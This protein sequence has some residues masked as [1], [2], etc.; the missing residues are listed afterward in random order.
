MI[1]VEF[2]EGFISEKMIG[3]NSFDALVKENT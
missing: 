2:A 3:F 1:G